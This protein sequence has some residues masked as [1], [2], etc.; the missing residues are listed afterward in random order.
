[1]AINSSTLL[2]PSNPKA[3]TESPADYS[4]LLL[5]PLATAVVYYQ[6][7]KQMRNAKRKLGWQLLKLK[8]KSLFSFKRKN[9][10]KLSKLAIIGLVCLSLGVIGGLIWGIGWGLNIILISACVAGLLLV[11]GLGANSQVE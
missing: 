8:L 5:L 7:K 2:T 9:G 1:M 3:A 6:T 10:K 11:M 4:P